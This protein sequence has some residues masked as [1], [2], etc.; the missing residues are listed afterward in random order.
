MLDL[1]TTVAAVFALSISLGPALAQ[2]AATGDDP[3]RT[4][5]RP[6]TT[7]GV[8]TMDMGANE[9][10]VDDQTTGSIRDDGDFAE[11]WRTM[12]PTEQE[13]VRANCDT[14]TM[15]KT[16]YSDNVDSLCKSFSTQ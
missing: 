7:G 13:K 5:P 4:F 14:M 10:L 15:D 1:K 16:L 8:Q 12:S 9:P 11:R 2:N 6:E 3:G